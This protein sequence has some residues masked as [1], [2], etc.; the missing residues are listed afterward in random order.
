[1]SSR[2]LRSKGASDGQSLPER[3][4]KTRKST[5]QPDQQ[6]MDQQCSLQSEQHSRPGSAQQPA[7]ETATLLPTP[8]PGQSPHCYTLQDSCRCQLFKWASYPG[9]AHHKYSYQLLKLLVPTFPLCLVHSLQKT[10]STPVAVT[11][12]CVTDKLQP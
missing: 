8:L 11:R 2:Q 9:P 4:R 7:G 6:T 1:M 3:T 10:G 5:D 12:R